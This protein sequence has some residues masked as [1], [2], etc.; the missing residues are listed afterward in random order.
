MHIC[1]CSWALGIFKNIGIRTYFALVTAVSVRVFRH[2][3]VWCK[4]RPDLPLFLL[5][6]N[7]A[8][9]EEHLLTPLKIWQLWA[10]KSS[11]V[12]MEPRY[13]IVTPYHVRMIAVISTGDM[14][15]SHVWHD[16]LICET[17]GAF[18]R[19]TWLI[20]KCDMTRRTYNQR[21]CRRC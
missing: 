5:H 13:T 9:F 4:K 20:H 8:F 16:P 2:F 14:P 18:T 10:L 6:L 12:F 11:K 1:P 15:H 21:V 7:T 3:C 17:G 19:E